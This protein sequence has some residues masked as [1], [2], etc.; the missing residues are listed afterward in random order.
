[1][2]C[3]PSRFAYHY[4]IF[5]VYP[6]L[7]LLLRA[8]VRLLATLKGLL[9]ESQR[10]NIVKMINAGGVRTEDKN[11]QKKQCGFALQPYSA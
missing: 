6:P 7:H 4:E 9:Q 2:V 5:T 1:M 10:E 8:V 3:C 11:K